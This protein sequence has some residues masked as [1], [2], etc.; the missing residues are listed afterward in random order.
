MTVAMPEVGS[1]LLNDLWD[2]TGLRFLTVHQFQT[3]IFQ[4]ASEWMD[5]VESRYS[6]ILI[7]LTADLVNDSEDISNPLN[8]ISRSLFVRLH[9]S[10]RSRRRKMFYVYLESASS[11]SKY[12]HATTG[13]QYDLFQRDVLCKDF[14][15]LASDLKR[16]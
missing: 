15:R 10:V 4:N 16:K 13:N 5:D 3:E 12:F 6:R 14:S 9:R 1:S 2:R 11:I 7:L 8:T